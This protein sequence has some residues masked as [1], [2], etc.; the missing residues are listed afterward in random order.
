MDIT[1]TDLSPDDHIA[2]YEIMRH[3]R[4]HHSLATFENFVRLQKRDYGYTLTGG[5]IDGTLAGVMGWRWLHTLA[6]GRHIHIDDLVVAPE[7]RGHHIGVALLDHIEARSI[8]GGGTSLNLDARA[9]A[10]GFYERS[11][12]IVHTAPGMVKRW[13][14]VV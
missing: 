1:C 4:P 2:A 7:Q 3:L 9:D 11:G 8:T 12:F 14:Q 10:I 6:R 5:F 13:G